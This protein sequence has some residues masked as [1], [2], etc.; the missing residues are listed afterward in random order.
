MQFDRQK[1]IILHCEGK[2]QHITTNLPLWLTEL[3]K[4]AQQADF[5]VDNLPDDIWMLVE[6]NEMFH[7]PLDGGGLVLQDPLH[8][9]LSTAKSSPGG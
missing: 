8:C 4:S 1:I 6:D 9:N 7:L 5:D 3:T 2:Q